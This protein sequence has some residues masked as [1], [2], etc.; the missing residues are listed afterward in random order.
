MLLVAAQEL[1]Q[2]PPARPVAILFTGQEEVGFVGAKAFYDYA[3]R[4]GIQSADVLN[5]DNLGRA[6]IAARASGARSGLVF[7][8]P[9]FGEFMYDGR[10]VAPASSYRQP[11]GAL[12]E[13]IQRAAPV[14]LYDRIVATSDGTYWQDR[15]W[16]AV[17]LS[18]ADMYYLEQTWHTYGDRV[19]LLEQGNLEQALQ[20]VLGYAQQEP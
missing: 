9:L 1:N 14:V 16:N 6:G 11:D 2:Q 19:E 17:N 4:N 5:F 8:V 7:T 10:N 15:G 18:S 20:L 12:L 13:R 3:T